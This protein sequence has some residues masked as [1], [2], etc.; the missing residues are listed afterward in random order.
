MTMRFSGSAQPL[1][2][3]GGETVKGAVAALPTCYEYREVHHCRADAAKRKN[4]LGG[5][6]ERH[7]RCVRA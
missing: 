2:D 5:M 1:V 6:H 7:H 3:N 4:L